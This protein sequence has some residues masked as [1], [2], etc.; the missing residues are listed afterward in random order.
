MRGCGGVDVE[1][2]E[3]NGEGSAVGQG[4]SATIG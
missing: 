1:S 4:Y 3:R 2:K